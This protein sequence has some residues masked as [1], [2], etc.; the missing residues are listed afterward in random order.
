M[1]VDLNDPWYV[2]TLS[3]LN[4]FDFSLDRL[5]KNRAEKVT[6][7]RDLKLTWQDCIGFGKIFKNRQSGLRLGEK[8]LNWHANRLPLCL[9]ILRFRHAMGSS[10]S[11]A[12]GAMCCGRQRGEGAPDSEETQKW[13]AW[14]LE[15]HV[16]I[17]IFWS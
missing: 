6:D 1:W 16:G 4:S 15:S 9:F 8:Q 17:S 12:M 14:Q 10:W 5:N 3:N 11:D 2:A 13:D 7:R